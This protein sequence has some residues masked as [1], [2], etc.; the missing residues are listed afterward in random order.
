MME[1]KRAAETAGMSRGQWLQ[2]R[3]RGIGGSD[4]P[5]LMGASPWAT[6]LSVYADKMG[7][8]PENE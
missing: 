6:P 5:A 1:A 8:L 4:A 7:F 2:A 3:R